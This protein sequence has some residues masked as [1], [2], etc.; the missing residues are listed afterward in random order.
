MKQEYDT[1]QSRWAKEKQTVRAQIREDFSK[2]RSDKTVLNKST[3]DLV[4]ANTAI[5]ETINQELR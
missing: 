5:R 3:Q 2:L 4:D 1:F